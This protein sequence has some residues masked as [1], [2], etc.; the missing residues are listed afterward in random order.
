[1]WTQELTDTKSQMELI[2]KL[3]LLMPLADVRAVADGIERVDTILPIADPTAYRD[4]LGTL[5]G[6]RDFVC[7]FLDF[8][9]ALERIV[10]GKR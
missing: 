1:M 4:L 2:G 9:K 10:E 8:R 5:A 3:A 6:H 7:A